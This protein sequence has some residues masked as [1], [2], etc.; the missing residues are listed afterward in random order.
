MTVIFA[1]SNC[2][3]DYTG[4]PQRENITNLPHWPMGDNGYSPPLPPYR[5]SIEGNMVPPGKSVPQMPYWTHQHPDLLV[6]DQD[7]ASEN[8]QEIYNYARENCISRFIYMGTATNMCVTHMRNFAI[9]QLKRFCG[10]EAIITR[11]TT[12]SHT[13]NGR[14]DPSMTP[15]RG[16]NESIAHIE[17]YI[18][19]SIDAAQILTAALPGAYAGQVAS[20]PDLLAY[21]RMDAADAGYRL[22]HDIKRTQGCWWYT[23]NPTFGAPGAIARDTNPAV[24]FAGDT[25]LLIAPSY[26]N[27]LPPGSP[28]ASLSAGDFAVDAWVQVDGGLG[29]D[30]WI[31]SHDDG[32]DG[33]VDFLLGL[34]AA[35][36]LRFVTRSSGGSFANDAVGTTVVTQADIDAGR[37]FHLVGVQDTAA[38]LVQLWVNGVKEAEI[39]LSGTA[40]NTLSS[41]QIASRGATTVDGSGIVTNAGFEFFHGA[42]DEVAVYDAA[43]DPGTIEAHHLM[44]TG[45]WADLTGDW[46]VDNDDL[47]VLTSYWLQPCDQPLW[48]EYADINTDHKVDLA[49]FAELADSWQ[50]DYMSY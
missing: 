8:L 45:N 29:S 36:R 40:V 15:D 32:T 21:W 17:Q 46:I 22:I 44:G 12:D 34:N 14:P 13:L 42:I 38:G 20:D 18:C 23:Q 1:P 2:F 27:D 3:E 50:R 41:L 24:R 47:G 16:H 43:L 31:V 11:D 49:D 6:K 30:Q 5:D 48:C 26:R 19:P 39:G 28:L 10:L 7:L 35:G 37:W 25:A 33:G 9:I 4:T